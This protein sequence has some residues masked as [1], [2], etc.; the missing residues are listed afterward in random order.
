MFQTRAAPGTHSSILTTQSNPINAFVFWIV[1]CLLCMLLL[2]WFIL[3]LILPHVTL[4]SGRCKNSHAE[5]HLFHQKKAFFFFFFN[6]KRYICMSLIT[7]NS[8]GDAR[9]ALVLRAVTH[10]GSAPPTPPSSGSGADQQLHVQL[11]SRTEPCHTGNSEDRNPNTSKRTAQGKNGMF[12]D[13]TGRPEPCL[14]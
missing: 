5:L 8:D 12:P 1:G 14:H 4:I 13:T 11:V 6:S 10:T 2:L 7:T 3:G 9:Q